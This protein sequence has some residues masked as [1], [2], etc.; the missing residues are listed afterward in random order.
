MH[1]PSDDGNG[2]AKTSMWR[3]A[4]SGER[5]TEELSEMRDRG[6]SVRALQ[7]GVNVVTESRLWTSVASGVAA[8]L[9][10]AVAKPSFATTT[11]KGAIYDARL[12]P[13][14]VAATCVVVA[15]CV[16]FMPSIVSMLR[17]ARR[18]SA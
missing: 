5:K 16:Y 18:A 8:A 3:R 2:G 12:S 15:A 11:R 4:I 1:S 9:L 14:R 13:T 10:L 7:A 17:R 6:R